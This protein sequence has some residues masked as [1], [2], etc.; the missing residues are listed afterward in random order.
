MILRYTIRLLTIAGFT[1]A[2]SHAYAQMFPGYQNS[3]FAGI[4]GISSNPAA[5]AGT[6][7]KWDVNIIGLDVKAGNTYVKAAKSSLFAPP[8]KFVRD[9]DYFLDTGATYKQYAWGSVDI[10]M[11]S[12]LYS[13]NTESSVAFSWRV[14]AMGNGGGIETSTANLLAE[15]FPD[16]PKYFNRNIDEKYGVGAAHA[17]NE[18]GFTYARTIRNDISGRWKGGATLKFLSGFGAGYGAQR[19]SALRLIN[20][21]F[22]DVEGE[23]FFGYNQE[24]DDADDGWQNAVGLFKNPG[25]ALDLG[26][27]YEWRPDN[28]GFGSRYDDES[29][30]N[31]DSDDF[32][33][34]LGISITD[35]GGISYTKSE[36]S[37]DLALDNKNFPID[38][39]RK[40]RGESL[41]QYLNRVG[42]YF[43]EVPSKDKFYMNLPTALNLMADYNINDRFFVSAN[44]SIALNS[45]TKDD[46]K[47]YALTQLQITPR[48]DI[49]MFGAYLPLQ[50]NRFG[51]ADAGVVLRAGPLVIGSASIFSNL[52]RQKINHADA[53]VALRLIPIHFN[54]GG[55]GWF[56][57][58]A[59]PGIDCP[60]MP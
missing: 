50:V 34:R 32:K 10:M 8:E 14:R 35:I 6:R 48:Y 31:P 23:V 59:R 46:H 12:V 40:V 28:D 9:E 36:S 47:T 44:A 16:N 52:M 39:L 21:R 2:T 4:H 1:L 11:P 20:N 29:A 13:I 55:G 25:V 33:A 45:F 49:N 43:Q 54:K 53:F 57:K 42:T 19:N 26:L 56:G 30:W 15:N 7:Y 37:R 51:Q 5:A 38:A 27:I 41:S 60:P 24:L 22:A 18:F 3:H 58:K 17:W